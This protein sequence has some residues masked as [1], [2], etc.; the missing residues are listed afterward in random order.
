MSVPDELVAGALGDRRTRELAV[1]LGDVKKTAL[2]TPAPT[3]VTRWLKRA[4]GTPMIAETKHA[5][6]SKDHLS[7]IPDPAALAREHEKD[8]A[9]AIPVLT[10]GRKLPDSLDD[11][12][13]VRAA[14]Y[15][16]MLCKDFI[17]TD[18]QIPEARAHGADLVL[19]IVA[20]LD[21]A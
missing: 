10:E 8:G 16:P 18:Y 2:A 11:F 12:D 1:S 3:D 9:S 14:V 4:D 15:I 21:D 6:P 19:L 13:R 17:V 7:D 5:P 20:A